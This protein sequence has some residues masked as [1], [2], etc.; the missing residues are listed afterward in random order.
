MP[1][2]PNRFGAN[3]RPDLLPAD[4]RTA[5]DIAVPLVSECKSPVAVFNAAGRH[6]TE[7]GEN[8]NVGT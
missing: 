5:A 4:T 6:P 2:S 7:Q 1:F 3:R 8:T